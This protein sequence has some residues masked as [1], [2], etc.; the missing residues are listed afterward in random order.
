MASCFWNNHVLQEED[1]C[2]LPGNEPYAGYAMGGNSVVVTTIDQLLFASETTAIHSESLPVAIAKAAGVNS[3][4]RGYALGGLESGGGW[5]TEIQGIE[6]SGGAAINPAAV[7]SVNITSSAGV[8]SATRGYSLGGNSYSTRTDEIQGIEFAGETAINPAAV[9]AVA[10]ELLAGVNSSTRGYA[11][12]GYGTAASP[13]YKTEIDG[14]EFAGETAINPAAVLAAAR[15]RVCGVN[16]STHG[17]AMGGYDTGAA[18][19]DKAEIDGIEFATES[20]VNP[21][22]ALSVARGYICGV[23]SSTRGYAMGGMNTSFSKFSVI[24]GIEFSS[25]SAFT[26]SATIASTV[27]FDRAGVQWGTL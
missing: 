7:L 9:L 1:S 2:H 26:L 19:W 18:P 17:Y 14:I 12:G 25:E 5:S 4:T 27:Y 23:N 13:Y 8:S 11:M 10:R 24:D 22:A 6:F 21:A 16:S 15:A 3:S 20:A